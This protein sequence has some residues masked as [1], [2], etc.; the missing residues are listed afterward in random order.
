MFDLFSTLHR[1]PLKR[2]TIISNQLHYAFSLVY[3]YYNIVQ[4]EINKAVFDDI[5]HLH[6]LFS[7]NNLDIARTSIQYVR[8]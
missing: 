3:S 1:G 8:T 2:Y 4:V 6:V 5:S 7:N